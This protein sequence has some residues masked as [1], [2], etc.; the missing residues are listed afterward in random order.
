MSVGSLCYQAGNQWTEQVSSCLSLTDITLIREAIFISL[1]A[2]L[3]IGAPRTALV[4]NKL[5]GNCRDKLVEERMDGYREERTDGRKERR[6][7]V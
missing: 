6:K 5:T 1:T 3:L 7:K 4:S 2:S